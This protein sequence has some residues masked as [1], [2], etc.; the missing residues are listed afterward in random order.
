MC[1]PLE[2]SIWLHEGFACA[3]GPVKGRCYSLLRVPSWAV[4]NRVATE[5]CLWGPALLLARTLGDSVFQETAAA[6]ATACLAAGQPLHTLCLLLAGCAPTAVL[7]VMPQPGAAPPLKHVLVKHCPFSSKVVC[8]RV[9]ADK[10]CFVSS[11]L[12]IEGCCC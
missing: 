6:M 11:K 3:S 5:G 8:A 4:L 12:L 1:P 7:P 10:I 2:P 9:G